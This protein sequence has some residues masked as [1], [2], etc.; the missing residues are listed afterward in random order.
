MGLFWTI[1]LA[2]T[3]GPLLVMLSFYL[4][5]GLL[6]MLFGAV[7]TPFVILTKILDRFFKPLNK[8][9]SKLS[10]WFN[11]LSKLNQYLLAI[12]VVLLFFIPM[13]VPYIWPL[14]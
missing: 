12:L 4:I 7:I 11:G 3:V 13:C 1:A 14:K 8:L 6:T 9:T 2:I 10:D 5:A